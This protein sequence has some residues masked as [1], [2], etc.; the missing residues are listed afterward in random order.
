M[1]TES[2]LKKLLDYPLSFILSHQDPPATQ[3][4][5]DCFFHIGAEDGVERVN[6]MT[7][8]KATVETG[9]LS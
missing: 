4:S 9:G 2:L 3:Q 1:K 5:Q 7:F 6:R 8:W